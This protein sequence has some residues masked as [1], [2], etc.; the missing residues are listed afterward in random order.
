[1]VRER[2][3][4]RLILQSIFEKIFIYRHFY[5]QMI[6]LV[7]QLFSLYASFASLK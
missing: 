1:M 5:R 3:P 2:L 6:A 7:D 4:L